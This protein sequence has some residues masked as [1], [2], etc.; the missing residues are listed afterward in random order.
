MELITTSSVIS[1]AKD[2]EDKSSKFY[3]ELAHLYSEE[4][5]L[6]LS[7][8]KE[9]RKNKTQIEWVYYSFISDAIEGCFSF[10]GIDTENYTLQTHIPEKI[11]YSDAIQMAISMENKI[12]KFHLNVTRVSKSLLADI[13]EI[14]NKLIINRKKRILTLKLLIK[15]N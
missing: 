13:S 10:E 4:E 2:L 14:F 11:S 7:F 5:N 8:E 9:N 1:F 6:F 3:E 12:T 15:N